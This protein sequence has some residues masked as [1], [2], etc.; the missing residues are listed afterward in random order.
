MTAS[1]NAANSDQMRVLV[2]A[3]AGRDAAVTTS[4]LS[5]EGLPLGICHSIDE[6]CERIAQGAGAAIVAGEALGPAALDLLAR[7]SR[8]QPPWSDFPLILLIGG[9]GKTVIPGILEAVGTTGSVT[10]LERPMMREALI[11]AVRVALRAR[12]RQYEI[13]D[14]LRER[15]RAAAALR[16][17]E[18]RFRIALANSPIGVAHV[19]RALRY[20]WMYNAHPDVELEQAL[21]KRL[22]DILPPEDVVE[23]TRL[24]EEVLSTGHSLRREISITFP[25]GR[26]VWD[27]TAEPLRD[28]AGKIV[29]VTT[30]AADL[31]EGKRLEA[32]RARLAAIVETSSDAILSRALD[33]TITSWNAAAERTFGYTATEAIGRDIGMLVPPDR[34]DE[35]AQIRR[36]VEAGEAVAPFETVRLTKDGQRLDVSVAVSP[37]ISADGVIV[38][39]SIITRDISERRRAQERQNLLLAELSHRVK[40]TLATVLSIANQTLSRAGSLDEFSRSF[41]G[42]IQA[43]AAAHNLLTAV[44][45]DVAPL[46]ALIEQALQPYASSDRSNVRISGDEVLLRPGAA[47]TFSLV[48]HELATNAAKYGAL[49]KPGGLVA[50]AC[51]V[52]SNDGREL[53]LH[54]A[55]TGGPP[56]RA[57]HH[58][59]FGL[60]LIERSVAHQLGGQAVLKYPIEGVSCA[61]TVPLADSV[62]TCVS[63]AQ[64]PS[65]SRRRSELDRNKAR[66]S[67]P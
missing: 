67:P 11:S 32:E 14:H 33:G 42:R 18:E 8:K 9:R 26:A 44:N 7:Y 51:R 59:G 17:S 60:E 50:V 65:S 1:D 52:R 13:R 34:A 61:I 63:G 58:R 57:P 22:D 24:R 16:Q 6:L 56:V 43:L 2:L 64:R 39:T 41:R 29:G 38:G 5:D 55:E 62:G 35:F 12:R 49:Q 3:P 27:V 10:L 21:G 40:N 47:L 4:V 66:Q 23:L 53:H 31:T 15:E 37:L 46:R 45:W 30:A 28:T 19:D 25:S 36:G 54:W 48:L 20:T